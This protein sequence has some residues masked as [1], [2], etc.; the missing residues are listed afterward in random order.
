MRTLPTACPPSQ[1]W[2]GT[3]G[4]SL[5]GKMSSAPGRSIRPSSTEP[6]PV[7]RTRPWILPRPSIHP[8][9]PDPGRGHGPGCGA[10]GPGTGYKLGCLPIGMAWHGVFSNRRV[11]CSP[12]A[13]PASCD[14]QSTSIRRAARLGSDHPE[15]CPCQEQ[16][17]RWRRTELAGSSRWL[18]TPRFA[19]HWL[20]G[21]SGSGRWMTAGALRSAPMVNGWRPTVT[22]MAA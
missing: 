11:T 8:D 21:R 16:V 17:A 12:T 10:L 2:P 1:L 18:T 20:K 5:G 9:E 14:G 6:W 3:A 7:P 4:S 22:I 13:R 19:S 15:V